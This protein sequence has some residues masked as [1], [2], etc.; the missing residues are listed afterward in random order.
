MFVLRLNIRSYPLSQ[1]IDQM[2]GD[3][4][5]QN[6]NKGKIQVVIS[7]LG[8]VTATHEIEIHSDTTDLKF[9]LEQN[10]LM[11]DDV[12]ITAKVNENSATTSRT[13]RIHFTH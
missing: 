8:Y 10:S 3:F 2:Q 11:L 1:S 13:I 4:A 5:I 7:C 6:V 9:Y 12:E